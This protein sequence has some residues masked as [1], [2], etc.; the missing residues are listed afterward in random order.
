[1]EESGV[2]SSYLQSGEKF[3]SGKKRKAGVGVGS[4]E[5]MSESNI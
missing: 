2:S 4:L 1:M 5:S 3:S